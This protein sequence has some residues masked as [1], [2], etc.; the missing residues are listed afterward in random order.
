M[1]HHLTPRARR[2]GSTTQV[3]IV[4]AG[5][6][7]MEFAYIYRAYGAEVTVLEMLPHLLPHEDDDV[8]V[9]IEQAMKKLGI[10]FRVNTK[11]ER[12]SMGEK[13][14]LQV[15]S[16]GKAE[17]IEAAQVLVAISVRPNVENIGLEAVGV[18]LERGA[19]KVDADCRTNVPGIYAIGDATMKMPLAH[20][21]S[22]QGKIAAEKIAG[23]APHPLNLNHVP[24]CTSVHHK[25]PRLV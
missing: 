3:V 21:A 6:I 5:P 25:L 10:R 22:A 16:E 2:A 11:V 13:V 14:Q 17:T 12:A 15:S 23:Q 7:G 4:G 20:V 8:S 24:R 18:E 19:I 1:G 9:E